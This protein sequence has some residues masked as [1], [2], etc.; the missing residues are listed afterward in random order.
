MSAVLSDETRKYDAKSP[1]PELCQTRIYLADRFPILVSLLRSKNNSFIVQIQANLISPYSIY[2]S[3]RLL[4]DNWSKNTTIRSLF[5][6]MNGLTT[7]MYGSF[8]PNSTKFAK[9]CKH[10]A[11]IT[12]DLKQKQMS[13]GFLS[14]KS[15]KIVI[16]FKLI[17][18]LNNFEI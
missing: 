14:N 17:L 7:S 6:S 12:R 1:N 11:T 4:T 5:F 18:E 16:I 13:I 10:F 8:P 15:F 3:V 9:F 2:I